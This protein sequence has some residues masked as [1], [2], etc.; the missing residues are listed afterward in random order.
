[1]FLPAHVS[2]SLKFWKYLR[3]LNIE[4]DEGRLEE[5]GIEVS[6]ERVVASGVFTGPGHQQEFFR[7]FAEE[8]EE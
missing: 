8:V 7:V 5:D 6:S 4:Q 1:V 3:V 2:E